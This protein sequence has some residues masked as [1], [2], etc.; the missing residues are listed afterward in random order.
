MLCAFVGGFAL[1]GVDCHP[2]G[3][4]P[5]KGA[6][7]DVLGWFCFAGGA[8]LVKAAMLSAFVGAFALLVKA[9]MLCAFVG[10]FALLVKAALLCAFVGA[11][12]VGFALVVAAAML[13]SA[14]GDFDLF[15]GFA[16]DI[17]LGFLTAPSSAS[18]CFRFGS[19]SLCL[20]FLLT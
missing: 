10:A 5:W 14:V 6:F 20:T 16:A 11:F 1:P 2:G 3:G 9:A 8:L 12:G 18:S 4:G 17:G 15:L 13:S 7:A 19:A